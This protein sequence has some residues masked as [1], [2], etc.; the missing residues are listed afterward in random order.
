MGKIRQVIKF[1]AV[2]MMF[3]VGA[4]SACAQTNIVG[5]A[6]VA[7]VP[8][9]SCSP[10]TLAFGNQVINVS[11]AQF[12]SICTNTGNAVVVLTSE[13]LSGAGFT[14]GP[15]N[16]CIAALN[17]IPGGN[18]VV[19]VVFTPTALAAFSGSVVISATGATGSPQTV[20][21]TG[22]GVNSGGGPPGAYTAPTSPTAQIGYSGFSP[23]SASQLPAEGGT[24]GV[25]TNFVHT[26]AGGISGGTGT[27][28]IQCAGQVANNAAHA[29]NAAFPVNSSWRVDAGSQKNIM[30]P[31]NKWLSLG[32]SSGF[33][34]I[35]LVDFLVGHKCTLNN[36]VG[37]G[38]GALLNASNTM[39]ASRTLADPNIFYAYASPGPGFAKV[40][41]TTG[42]PVITTIVANLNSLSNPPCGGGLLGGTGGGIVNGP[43]TIALGRDNILGS[44]FGTVLNQNQ[45]QCV[46]FYQAA[47]GAIGWWNVGNDSMGSS[48][49]IAWTGG[50]PSCASACTGLSIGGGGGIHAIDGVSAD[51]NFFAIELPGIATGPVVMQ[52]GTT[53][54][55]QAA[56]QLSGNGHFAIIGNSICALSS[57]ANPSTG[58]INCA[59]LS[60]ITTL[61]VT[62]GR[63]GTASAVFQPDQHNNGNG[64]SPSG[65]GTWFTSSYC[66]VQP[67]CTNNAQP[68]GPG[69]QEILAVSP[70]PSSG[71]W[72]P[73]FWRFLHTFMNYAA[74]S[75][76]TAFWCETNGQPSWDQTIFIYPTNWGGLLG[77]DNGNSTRQVVDLAETR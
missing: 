66:S 65:G 53:S 29:L 32:S 47:T 5:G 71:A 23:L 30:T 41:M 73:T 72:T 49:G 21:L 17:I 1:L 74:C 19:S 22:T 35:F 61:S 64:V 75:G 10:L 36:L 7:S 60:A 12:S 45:W 8:A 40:D 18:C 43:D 33:S 16:T 70:P 6:Q 15:S 13:V 42:T 26:S 38:F 27:A 46:V 63:L 31:N 56:S 51:N 67:S 54:A 62:A 44:A 37:P 14:L 11:S 9:Y 48:G 76:Q 69:V 25:D 77:N 2:L 28:F 39:T 24:I 50:W 3:C 59:L 4:L 34:A 55:H 58:A 52:L 57:G 20:N 68:G